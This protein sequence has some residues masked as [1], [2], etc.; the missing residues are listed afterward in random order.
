MLNPQRNQ[1]PLSGESSAGVLPRIE[2]PML[3]RKPRST[4]CAVGS[5]LD[6]LVSEEEEVGGGVESTQ[7]LLSP[8][9]PQGAF[10]FSTRGS[11]TSSN[12]R[13]RSPL[14][15]SVPAPNPGQEALRKIL[16]SC[17][18]FRQGCRQFYRTL[19]VADNKL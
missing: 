5:R 2:Q 19:E 7:A 3:S 8:G 15:C 14:G 4:R 9:P 16:D 17:R 18:D 6:S 13:V 11:V 10:D 1:S 12:T